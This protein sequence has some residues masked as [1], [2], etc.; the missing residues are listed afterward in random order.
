MGP[1]LSLNL[2]WR[3]KGCCSAGYD[4]PVEAKTPPTKG[5]QERGEGRG[6]S[7]A[8]QPLHSVHL[9]PSPRGTLGW[10]VSPLWDSVVLL[11]VV[12]VVVV[13]LA[14]AS[15]SDTA[16]SI[17]SI[18]NSSFLVVF[19]MELFVLF[20]LMGAA[21]GGGA[22]FSTALTGMTVSRTSVVVTL[23]A[24]APGCCESSRVWMSESSS[25]MF[26]L[27]RPSVE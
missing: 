5:T 24:A 18:L 27:R 17:G 8:T 11:V 26:F 13:S 23:L 25:L 3:E 21:V 19:I 10:C 22:F 20:G 4:L 7:R 6:G 9:L 15:A 2:T 16:V 1:D 14:E 12:V